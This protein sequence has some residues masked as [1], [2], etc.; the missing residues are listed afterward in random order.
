MSPVTNKR[1]GWRGAWLRLILL[2]FFCAAGL[3]VAPAA[4]ALKGVALVIGNGA[5]EHLDKLANPENDAARIK[6]ILDGLGFEAQSTS[7]RDLK[8]LKRD[9]EDFVDDAEG[10]DVAVLYYSGHGI[11]AGGENYLVP[12]DADISALEDADKELA[13][14]SLIVKR[15]QET[16]PVVIVLLD[17]CR[18]NP[19][20]AG[21]T[22]KASADAAPQ[23][24]A[25]SGLGETRGAVVLGGKTADGRDNL[26]TVL[27][28]SAAPGE[29]ALDGDPGSNSPYAAAIARHL[30]AMSGMD[31]GLVMRMVAEEVYLKTNGKQR[32][33]V[34]ES[35]RRLL[36]FGKAPTAA[37]GDEGEILSERRQLLITIADLPDADRRQ[38]ETVAASG[39]VPMD[40]VYGMLKA[41]GADHPSD[42]AELDKLLRSQTDKLKELMEERAT[43]QSADPEIQR[44]SKLADEAIAEGALKSAL[45]LNERA[46][47][48]L[49]AIDPT[50][51]Q[52]ESDLK[53]RRV[54]A[55]DVYARSAA[56]YALAFNYE[57]AA[58]DYRQ[59]FEQVERWDEKLAWKY[60]NSELGAVTT[61][62]EMRG[63]SAALVRAIDL[64]REALKLSEP[65]GKDA[66][67]AATQNDLG[68]ALLVLGARESK[69]DRL[70]DAVKAFREALTIRTRERNLFDWIQT[71]TNLAF[72]M[73]RIGEREVGTAT[74]QESTRLDREMLDDEIRTKYPG[75]Y[76]RVENNLGMSLVRVAERTGSIADYEAAVAALRSALEIQ[77]REAY[78]L[79][80]AV[81]QHNL[82]LALWRMGER[83]ED[84]AILRQS[85]DA[86]RASLQEL[87]RDRAPLSW[88]MT[89]GN[90]GNVLSLIGRIEQNETM[91]E[92]AIAMLK[93]AL[94]VN[95]VDR[96]ASDW[97]MTQINLSYALLQLG[98]RRGDTAML[99]EAVD[100]L[101]AAESEYSRDRYPILWATIQ[102][103]RG[104]ALYALAGVDRDL[105]K[106]RR[107]IDSFDLALQVRKPDELPTDWALSIA[108][109]GV[110][111]AQLGQRTN[112]RALMRE[113]RAAVAEARKRAGELGYT[114]FSNFFDLKLKLIDRLLMQLSAH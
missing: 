9:L 114:G 66:E 18:T 3:N 34:N 15:L 42:P 70:F 89:T 75:S 20:P 79:D 32:P 51:D 78:P 56:T 95:T 106:Y 80:W 54:E 104:I 38:I 71:Q 1:A 24:I 23:T 65:F 14:L 110:T 87:T 74:L 46:K 22:L 12:I 72:A 16:T 94:E 92:D 2:F 57:Q 96:A 28:F 35:L 36:Y 82:G 88:A 26:G 61:Q 101:A 10:A 27:G 58:A 103:N 49:A 112:D 8:R 41:L 77:T 52:A 53:A 44:L 113:G 102:Q 91:I 30:D 83:A 25:A 5:Y 43:L 99:G 47:A 107:A 13:P 98:E 40:A 48:R 109:K 63:D 19:F 69:S 68:Y 67:W 59:A 39:K 50:L 84:T 85:L 7:D 17:A 64:G 31:F 29:A 62:G 111:M 6:A 90:L 105:S 108:S 21:A 45:A 4:N 37:T 76:A 81:D 100:A 11:E 60:K 93:S 86:Y 55:A 73:F 33:W 97:A